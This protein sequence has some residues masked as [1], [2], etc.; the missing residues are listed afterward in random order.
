[1]T[2]E[3][4]NCWFRGETCKLFEVQ[5]RESS[6]EE[7]NSRDGRWSSQEHQL[8]INEILEQGQLNWKR[9]IFSLIFS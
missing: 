4:E 3:R 7:P 2:E 6:L 9:V 5:K 8:L 1:M